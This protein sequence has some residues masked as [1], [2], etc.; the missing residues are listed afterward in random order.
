MTWVDAKRRLLDTLPI[1]CKSI[2]IA[3][4]SVLPLCLAVVCFS[5]CMPIFRRLFFCYLFI[6][7]AVFLSCNCQ[8]VCLYICFPSISCLSN[9]H[10]FLPASSLPAFLSVANLHIRRLSI[11]CHCLFITRLSVYCHSICV[12]FRH[13]PVCLSPVCLSISCLSPVCQSICHV[14]VWPSIVPVLGMLRACLFSHLSIC[15]S[16]RPYLNF[17]SAFCLPVTMSPV[18]LYVNRLSVY[19]S[20]PVSYTVR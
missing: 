5:I 4:V 17:L 11:R 2:S 1:A 14:F 16:F 20:M 19:Q 9:R 3:C 6:N 13:L 18:C 12:S 7:M 10:G 15:L 8:P